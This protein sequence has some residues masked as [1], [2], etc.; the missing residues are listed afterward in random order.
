MDR[1]INVER[2]GDL[3]RI[4]GKFYSLYDA[5][6]KAFAEV[7]AF[8]SNNVA[9]DAPPWFYTGSPYG[10]AILALGPIEMPSPQFFRAE[11]LPQSKPGWARQSPIWPKVFGVEV[12]P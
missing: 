7:R 2:G 5:V 10:D 12:S 3:L 1:I 6:E 8:G 4:N 9:F 11:Y